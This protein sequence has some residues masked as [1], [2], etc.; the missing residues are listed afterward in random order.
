M[1]ETREDFVYLAKLSEQAERYDGKRHFYY[2]Y[3]YGYFTCSSFNLNYDDNY[4]DYIHYS[5]ILT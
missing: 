3:N 4:C 2:Y 1:S 5:R